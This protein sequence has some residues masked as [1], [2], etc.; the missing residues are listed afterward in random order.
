MTLTDPE[1]PATGT[2]TVQGIPEWDALQPEAAPEAPPAAPPATQ[3]RRYELRIRTAVGRPLA[4]SLHNSLRRAVLPRRTI[5]RLRIGE[6]EANI[7]L[8]DVLQRLTDR[9]IDV[10]DIRVCPAPR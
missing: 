1:P 4:A 9:D 3:L 2:P 5:Y 8:A 10:L 7:D 6:D